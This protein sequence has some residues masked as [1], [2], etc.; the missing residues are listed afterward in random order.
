MLPSD[1]VIQGMIQNKND[2]ELWFEESLL[3]WD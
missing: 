3:M 2:T 1:I